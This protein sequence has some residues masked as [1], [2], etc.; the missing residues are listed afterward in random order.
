MK[1]AT[2][3][4]RIV[5][6]WARLI[7]SQA[8]VGQ[9][10]PAAGAGSSADLTSIRMPPGASKRGQTGLAQLQIGPVRYR[11]DQGVEP[12]Q[13]FQRRQLEPVLGQ[14]GR[15]SAPAGRGPGPRSRSSPARRRMSGTRLLRRSGTFS[16]KVSPSTPTRARRTGTSRAISSLTSFCA[17]KA[18]MPSLIRRPARIT[19]GW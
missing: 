7:G 2:P 17:T 1:P 19:S 16:L 10:R 12:P 15:G 4:S 5:P 13:R 18:P 6:S 14:G 8:P 11:Q 9:R 3:V